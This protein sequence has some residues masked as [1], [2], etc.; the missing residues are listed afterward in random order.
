M[1]TTESSFIRPDGTPARVLVVDD[2]SV[3]AELLGSALRHQ[4]WETQT[5]AN[6]WEALDKADTFD[7]DVV[8]LD[9][10]MP[11][12][13]GMETLER[14]RKR[15]PHLP[16]LFLT[17]RD[18]V[19]DRVAGLRAGADDY[20]TKPF[21]PLELTARVKANLR[22]FTEFNAEKKGGGAA[23][24]EI[25]E[26]G[27]LYINKSTREVRTYDK[28]AKLTPIE[29]DILCL[30]ASNPGRV[31]STDDIF[32]RVWNEKAFEGNNTVMVHIRRLREKI[33]MD[34][35]NAKIIKTVWGV[36]YKIEK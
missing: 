22:R 33:E 21:N 4:G 34:A 26:V 18:A 17:A 8:V 7:P 24:D 12:L 2:E 35:R 29:Y 5:A 15:K 11:G 1:S 28:E 32:T 6:G 19:A 23:D 3:L 31:F 20:V 16:V 10:Q 27:P 9:I 36:G 30:L 13:D 14:L 25:I